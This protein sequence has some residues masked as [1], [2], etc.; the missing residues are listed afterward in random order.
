MLQFFWLII[1]PFA[2]LAR[3]IRKIARTLFGQLSWTP[4]YWLQRGFVRIHLYRRAH[5]ILVASAVLL[6]LLLTS[7]SL[8][9]W[10]W[11]QRQPKPRTVHANVAAIPVTPLDKELKFPPLTIDFSE[12]AARL[13]DLK[14]PAVQ[15]VRLEPATAGTWKWSNDSKLVFTPTQDWPAD[16]RFRIIFDRDLFPSHVRMEKLEYEASTP[17]F[18][19]EIHTVALSEDAKEP[20][21]QRVTATIELTHAV[22]P[23]EIDKHAALIMLGGS[24][25]FGPNDPT[26]HFS[27]TYGPHNRRAFL[28][29]SPVV[30][31]ANEDFIRVTI[32]KDLRTAQGGAEIKEEV[33]QKLL[34]PSKETAFKIKSIDGSVVRN[35]EGEPEQ[36]LN[37]ETSSDISTAELAKSLHIYLLPKREPEKSSASEEEQSSEENASEENSTASN[38]ENAEKDTAK[39]KAEESGSDE[40]EDTTDT[41]SAEKTWANAE[42]VTDDILEQATVVK[43]TAIPTEKDFARDHHFKFKLEGDGQLYVRVDKGLHA[44]SGYDLAENFINVLAAPELPQEIDI[45]GDGGLLA[46]SGERKL[47]IRSRGVPVIKFEI[48]RV[49]STEINHLVSQTEGEFQAPEFKHGSFDQDNISRIAREDQAISLQNK[50]KANYSAFGLSKYL[51]KPADGGSE[52]GLFFV[53]ARGWDPVTKRYIK[54]ATASR[55]ILVSDLGLLVKKNADHTSDLFV[56][57]IKTGQPVA[58]VTVELLGRNGIPVQSAKTSADGRVTFASVEKNEHEKK[59]VVYVARLGDDISFIPFARDDRMLNFSR[60]DVEGVTTVLAEDLDA[61]VFTERGVYR[62][63]DEMHIGLVIKQRNWQGKL[64]GLPVETEVIDARAL[65]VQT[66][67]IALPAGGLAE[68]SYTTSYES[69]TGEYTINVYL[70]KNNKRSTLL[71]STTVNVKEFLP[72]RMKIETRLSKNSV[73]GWVDPKEMKASIALANLYGTP[74]TDRKVKSRAELSPADFS[75]PEFKDYSFYDSLFD[76]KKVRQHETVDLGEQQTN[77]SG[78][79]DFDLQLDRFADATYSMQFFAE[80]FEGEG[81]RSV[82]GQA[83]V[84]VSAL[85][86]VVG[87]KTDGNLSY[88]SAN[89]PLAVDL[90]AVDPQLKR[91]AL[92]NVTLDVIAEEHVSVVAKKENGSYGYESVLKERVAKSEKIAIGA[93]GLRYQLPTSEPGDYIVE[94][95]D[96]GGRKVSRIRFSVVGSGIVK[97]ALDKNSELQV[98]LARTKY[99]SGEEVEISITAPY[100]GSGLITIERDKVYALHWFKTDAASSVQKI[101]VPDGFEGS[102]Y[103]NVALIRALDSKEVFTSPLSYGVVPFTANIEK[104]RLKV[105][106]QT[107]A[108]AKPGE[109]FHISYKTDRPSKIAVFAVDQGIL[110]VSDYKLPDPLGFFFRKCALSVETA[111]IMDLIMPEFSILR[112]MSAFGGDGDNPKQLNPFRRV[113]EKPVVYWSGIVDADTTAREV[114]YNVPDYFSGTLTVMAVAV[115]DDATGAAQKDALIRGPFVITPSVPVL[116]APGD[117][118]EAGVTVA[119]NVEG[120]GDNAEVQIRAE[121]SEHV[122]IV[123]TPSQTLKISEGREQTTS[124][125]VHVNDKLGSGT[126]TFIATTGGKETRLRSTISVRPP[127][128]FMTQVRSNSFTKTS[129]EVPITRDMYPEFRKLIASVSALPL[130]LAHGLDVYLKEF[131]HGCSEQITSGAFCRLVLANEADFGLDRKDVNAQ[132]ENVFSVLRR[133]Q[134]DRGAF[135]YW[136]PEK[137]AG[138]D[139]MSVY[140]MHF[141]IE[142]KAAGFAPPPE[143]FTSGLRNLQAMVAK[144]PGGLDDAR[145]VAYAIYLLSREGVVTTNYILNL[146]DYLDKNFEKTWAQDLTGVY[147]AGALHILKKEDEAG[148]LIA[149]YKIG[150]HDKREITDFYQP[151]GADSQYIAILAREFPARLKKLSAPEFE[152]ILKP[153][154]EGS[155]N[156]LSAAY[157]VL[158]LKSYSQMVAQNPPE[159]TIEEIDKAKKAKAL[160]SGKKLL[161]RTNFSGDAGAI[162]FRS[163]TPLNPPG[164]FYQVIEAGFDRQISNKTIADGLEIYRELLDKSGKPVTT[165]Q[166]GDVITVKL[167]VRSLRQESI[168][169]VAVVDLLPGGFEIVGSSL[170]P[171]ISSINGV[172]YVEV[173]EDRAVFY[174]TVPTQTLEITYQIKSCNRGSFVVPPVFAESMYDRNVKA[175]GLGGKISVTK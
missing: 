73:H 99:N 71:G 6:V 169:N 45:Q 8:W 133:R 11:Y 127:A 76:E 23:G 81:G 108:L 82:T 7:G 28:R 105:D 17:P 139:F 149:R 158:A 78:A 18:R 91:I 75:F 61:F 96:E 44:R 109:P 157:A 132:L 83:S 70:V 172:D 130:G 118:F 166:L 55:F 131:P 141:L 100:A 151:L 119:N 62:P 39:S 1:R 142:A 94:L 111:Q 47:S 10:K 167:R 30:L 64:T 143:M 9:T 175:R 25:V 122:Q 156:T 51:Q 163:A 116:A 40:G 126:I 43:F 63:G 92:Q 117:D 124:F 162:R 72:D 135:G 50:W 152:N 46:L 20:G 5:P 34:I 144:E 93:D 31:P 38:D 88:V 120:S 159:L 134:N 173:R 33:E 137:G 52:R 19:A 112:S 153:V 49:L 57:S 115:A 89:T 56:A 125:A 97:R 22:E 102:G 48:D 129:V 77:D 66:K 150:Q 170:S 114:V 84:L 171:G 60:F 2:W 121:S 103:I 90:L 27:I 101:K 123:K 14:N 87:Y 104:R 12:P 54:S 98:K 79:A 95:R 68:I 58:G 65:T 138:I 24:N 53:K 59:A 41:K 145:T 168:T 174:A 3:F 128:T 13:E 154:S 67:K 86:Y 4:P 155:F 107:A 147:L 37:V 136:G 140:A 165:T 74:A 36:I 164:A 35:K 160:T 148:K 15:H 26:P 161:Q 85:P 80:A 21:V 106:L 42:E 110:Q 32:N 146:R 16:R 113:T 29:S 69:P